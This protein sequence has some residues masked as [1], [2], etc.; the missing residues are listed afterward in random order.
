V[1]PTP[2]TPLSSKS[3][4]ASAL[5]VRARV[6]HARSH[7][8]RTTREE[9]FLVTEATLCSVSSFRIQSSY[10]ALQRINQDL[11]EKIHRNVS[12]VSVCVCVCVCVC[13]Y[14]CVFVLARVCVVMQAR[15]AAHV[16]VSLTRW[17]ASG[18]GCVN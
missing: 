4:P 3:I 1:C 10:S 8:Y 17:K 6:A 7:A 5:L 15:H 14:V 16:M 12:C 18:A 13:V 11:E 2:H 9:N